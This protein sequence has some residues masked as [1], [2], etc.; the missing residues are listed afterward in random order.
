ME[1]AKY[2]RA[3]RNAREYSQEYMANELQISQSYYSK[4]KAQA[5]DKPFKTVA[6][7]LMVLEVTEA[8]AYTALQF[9]SLKKK[10]IPVAE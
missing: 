3:I 1:L 2:I 7:V 6:K 8:E 5:G 10:S 9:Y 4:I